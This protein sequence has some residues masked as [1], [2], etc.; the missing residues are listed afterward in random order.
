MAGR[1]EPPEGAPEGSP[2]G[3]DEYRS[4]VFDESF[5]RAARLQEYSARERLGGDHA[6]AAVRS[7][8]PKHVRRGRRRGFLH[9]PRQALVLLLVVALAFGTAIYLG[10]RSPYRPS[11]HGTA[12]ALRMTVIPLAPAGRVPGGTPDDLFAHS[13]AAQFR[14][15]A[16]GITL[17]GVRGTRSF[18]ESQVV[19]ALTTVKDYLVASSLDPDVLAG[20]T[21]R[22]VRALLD[23]DQLTQF[24]RS[25]SAPADDGRHVPAGW[26][27][28]FDPA[29]VA[30][31]ADEV[32]VHGTLRVEETGP[33]I[34]EVSSDHTFVYALR[35]A[36]SSAVP[37]RD[38]SLFTVRR[39]LRFRFDQ[40][41]L[42]KHQAELLLS[43]AQVGPQACSAAPPRTLRPLLAGA[44]TTVAERPPGTNPFATGPIGT[45]L[46]GMLSTGAEPKP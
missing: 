29:K 32:R 26:L 23:P 14:A 30:P 19:A 11:T 2:N 35:P 41:D 16:A 45:G 5:I 44:R 8:P 4:V 20:R 46:C 17:P 22:P 15:G 12:E 18:T 39:E 31:A 25:F 21:V 33:G 43:Q 42:A 40:N 7:L 3:D 38:A 13:P 34:L 24:D 1:G 37:V 9:G 36:A 28:R 27:V 6:H 10:V